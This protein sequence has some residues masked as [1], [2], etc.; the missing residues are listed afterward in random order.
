M[1]TKLRFFY[2]GE[3]CRRNAEMHLK[4]V[5]LLK[6]MYEPPSSQQVEASPSCS[7][8]PMPLLR[9]IDSCSSALTSCSS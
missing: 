9:T 7:H 3:C 8:K 2:S 6:K 4:K 1:S 5:F